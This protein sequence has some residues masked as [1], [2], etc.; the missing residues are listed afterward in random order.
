MILADDYDSYDDYNTFDN[1]DW[2]KL[3]I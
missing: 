1:D 2:F 3:K